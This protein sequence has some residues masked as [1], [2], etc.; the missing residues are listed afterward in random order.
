MGGAGVRLSE[1]ELIVVRSAPP[2]D[3]ARLRATIEAL[4]A[5]AAA[6]AV[7][8]V[9][10]V[11]DGDHLELALAFAGHSPLAP[12]R[13]DELA[14]LA[15]ALAGCLSDLHLHR[16]AH[17]AISREHVLVDA[18]GVV[19]LCGFGSSV[20]ASPGDDVAAFGALVRSLLDERDDS[21]S[22]EAL[23]FHADRCCAND[24][25][26]RPTM[27]AIAAALASVDRAL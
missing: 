18:A 17:G 13:G 6:G 25:S 16:L 19:R 9:E 11:D 12:I 4:R 27:A 15:G 14:P 7:E 10:V 23:R 3:P 21:P 2:E 22:A 8:I 20:G 26:A 5:A 1:G 24:A